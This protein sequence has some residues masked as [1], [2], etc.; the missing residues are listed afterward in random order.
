[1]PSTM[2]SHTSKFAVEESEDASADEQDDDDDDEDFGS[3]PRAPRSA[4][5]S[6][7]P[8]SAR[9]SAVIAAS[10]RHYVL[11]LHAAPASLDYTAKGCIWQAMLPLGFQCLDGFQPQS[12]CWKHALSCFGTSAVV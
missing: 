11:A 4:G 6:S 7:R 2:S 1:M 10:Y 3:R 8:S 12:G 9:A 5:R